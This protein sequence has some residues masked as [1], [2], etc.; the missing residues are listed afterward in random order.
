LFS[1]GGR[2]QQ[3]CQNSLLLKDVPSSAAAATSGEEKASNLSKVATRVSLQQ[4][5]AVCRKDGRPSPPRPSSLNL[6]PNWLPA[7]I[8]A[9]NS[10]G[11]FSLYENNLSAAANDPESRAAASVPDLNC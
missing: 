5:T 8:Q 3:N 2:K 1:D 4:G 9:S 6:G 10:G 11:R 7:K